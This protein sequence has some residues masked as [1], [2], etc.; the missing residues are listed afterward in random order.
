M[1]I[2][3]NMQYRRMALRREAQRFSKVWSEFP[4]CCIGAWDEDPRVASL[5]RAAEHEMDMYL[6]RQD[7]CISFEEAM[8][9]NRFLNKYR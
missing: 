3:K 2:G 4:T 7:G 8:K 9:V 5:V 6:E 1:S